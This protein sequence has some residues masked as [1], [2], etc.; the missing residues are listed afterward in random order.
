MVNLPPPISRKAADDNAPEPFKAAEAAEAVEAPEAI[1]PGA[2]SLA[3]AAGGGGGGEEIEDNCIQGNAAGDAS[4]IQEAID[5]AVQS[6]L[7]DEIV[8][9]KAKV[10]NTHREIADQ[11]HQVQEWLTLGKRPNQ[12]RALCAELWGLKTRAAEQRIHDARKQMVIDCND[13]DRKDKVGQMLQQLEEVLQQALDM[14]QGSNAIGAIRLQA[15]L[16]QL[17]TRQN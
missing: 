10:G 12:I 9:K 16:L 17:L 13:M 14:R 7:L 4:V 15:D 1:Q 3:E 5:K 6:V 8:Q 11:V 2:S